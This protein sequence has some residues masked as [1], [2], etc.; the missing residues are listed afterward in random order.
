MGRI[1]LCHRT[2]NSPM[3]ASHQANPHEVQSSH[4]TGNGF[5]LQETD[6]SFGALL[7][8]R[9]KRS[10]YSFARHPIHFPTVNEYSYN[11]FLRILIMTLSQAISMR[12]GYLFPKELRE[13]PLGQSKEQRNNMKTLDRPKTRSAC[14]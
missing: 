9:V 10:I 1:C 2:G 14:L 7:S 8:P 6:P 5:L 4:Q 11:F 13:M 3:I 12:L